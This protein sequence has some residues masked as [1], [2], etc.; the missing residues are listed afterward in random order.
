MNGILSKL[1]KCKC[2]C[3]LFIRFPGTDCWSQVVLKWLR[4]YNS[5]LNTAMR[6]LG[7]WRSIIITIIITAAK[8]E[9]Y[10]TLLGLELFGRAI[11]LKRFIS[12]SCGCATQM[13]HSTSFK[14]QRNKL[15]SS[16]CN[17]SP[18]PDHIDWFLQLKLLYLFLCSLKSLF[19]HS[20]RQMNC[21]FSLGKKSYTVRI[22]QLLSCSVQAS[23]SSHGFQFSKERQLFFLHKPTDT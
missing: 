1:Q 2:K 5:S 8:R 17:H 11:W 6:G 3:L 16:E 13:A 9:H 4:M 7:Q 15:L 18:Y 19:I 23:Y 12:T 20:F 10:T 22:I 21:V 14:A